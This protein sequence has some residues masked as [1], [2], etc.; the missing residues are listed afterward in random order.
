MAL[1][2]ASSVRLNTRDWRLI[3][4]AVAVAAISLGVA[5]RYFHRA[6]PEA[7]IDFQVSGPCSTQ[8][9]RQFLAARGLDVRGFLQAEQFDYD[10]NAKTFLERELGLQRSEQLLGARI[11]LWRWENRWF[12]PLDAEEVDVAVSTAGSVV[13]FDHHLADETPGASLTEDQ[14]RARAQQFLTAVL[15]RGWS[16]WMPIG[17]ER[18]VKPH[19]TDY[20]F[21]WKETQPLVPGA[22]GQLAAAEVRH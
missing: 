14:A 1:E 17:A 13:A 18:E 16:S 4:V 21:T 5:A 3:L 10:D 6:F 20:T 7:S 12:K 15:H 11:Q 8:V 22:A 19:R 9:A 2:P